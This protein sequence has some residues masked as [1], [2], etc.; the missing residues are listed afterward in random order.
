MYEYNEYI[1][2]NGLRL[3]YKKTDS[4]LASISI[5]IDAGA[6]RDMEGKLGI[7]H[8]TEHMVY[9][10]TKTRSEDEINKS[11]S[12][13]FGFQNAMTN[14]PYVIYYGTLLNDDLENAVEL[15]SDILIN[16]SFKEEGFKEEMS[17]I[18]EELNEWDEE[19]SQFCEDILFYNC[20]KKRRIKYPIIGVKEDLENLTMEDIKVFYNKFYCANNSTVVIAS[21]MEFLQIKSI[22]EKYFGKWNKKFDIDKKVIEEKG[23]SAKY[24]NKREGINSSK[25]LITYDISKLS[26]KEL[27]NF[28]IFNELFGEGI[29]SLLFNS[30]RTKTGLVYDVLTYISNEKHINLYKITFGTASEKVSEALNEI[31]SLVLQ[32]EQI[33]DKLTDEDIKK[34]V[35]QLKL[36]R[37]FKEEQTIRLTNQLAMYDVMFNDYKIYLEEIEN[38]EDISKDTLKA[39]V[40]KVL[41]EP[42]IQIVQ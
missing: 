36:R 12:E 30:L 14:Y 15:F 24:I 19:V 23:I 8:A 6:S 1:L 18:K 22:I 7:A 27:K 20:Y 9:K 38:L 21:S 17:V 41:V 35:K 2:S 4:S 28:R 31:S 26:Y 32:L 42:C 10:G 29:N 33:I 39:V 13:I 34:L 25:V 37:L 16:P 5:A 11:L 40:K 3:V